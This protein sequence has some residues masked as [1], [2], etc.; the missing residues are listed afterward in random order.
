VPRLAGAQDW[1]LVDRDPTLLGQVASETAGWASG[2]GLDARAAGRCLAIRGPRL[3]CC[4]TLVRADLT[5][6]L[7]A[8]PFEGVDL[9]ACSALLDLVSGP[10]LARLL[11]QCRRHGCAFLAALS[12]DGS[13][14]WAPADPD[15]DR[16][17]NL[18][19]RHQR[20]DKG[21]GPA[22][23]PAATAFAARRLARLGY[24]VR[25]ASSPWRLGPGEAALQEA[26]L[27]GWT[28]AARELVPEAGTSLGDW[29]Y[30]RLSLIRRG[31]SRLTVGHLDL[32][33][34]PGPIDEGVA[35]GRR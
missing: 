9:V 27:E 24:R 7:E 6:R 15:D 11:A 13:V 26:L 1:L 33:A 18:V 34:V 8:L 23:G 35:R 28:T 32:F 30:R 21:F 22:L 25:A 19:N 4:A 29:A 12:Y 16:V 10:W 14:T 20:T 5:E 31:E 17:R 2:M 3:A